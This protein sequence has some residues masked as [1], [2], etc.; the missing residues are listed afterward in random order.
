MIYLQTWKQRR[1]AG[2]VGHIEHGIDLSLVNFGG[3]LEYIL[4]SICLI[5]ISF[6]YMS[7]L[8]SC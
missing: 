7:F 4:C 5:N 2:S 1:W 8:P 6:A 3:L